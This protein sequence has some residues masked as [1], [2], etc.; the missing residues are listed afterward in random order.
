MSNPQTKEALKR[1]KFL[2][3]TNPLT[4]TTT[5]NFHSPKEKTPIICKLKGKLC[6]HEKLIVCSTPLI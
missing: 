1:V 5:N 6:K 4:I 3:L 2:K